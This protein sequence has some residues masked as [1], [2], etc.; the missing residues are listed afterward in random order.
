[1]HVSVD[2]YGNYYNTE[3]EVVVDAAHNKS[4]QNK[5]W[6]AWGT[7]QEGLD[8]LIALCG[9][10]CLLKWDRSIKLY[11]IASLVLIPPHED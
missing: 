1:M 3:D 10:T 2:H 5:L 8:F 7:W 6:W 11:D 9:W 4:L